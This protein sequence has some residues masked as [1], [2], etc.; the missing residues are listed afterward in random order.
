MYQ[1]LLSIGSLINWIYS[2]V[3]LCHVSRIHLLVSRLLLVSLISYVVCR[4]WRTH[5]WN[6]TLSTKDRKSA[7]NLSGVCLNRGNVGILPLLLCSPS[8]TR[9]K[10]N[11]SACLFVCQL[12]CLS[13]HLS[14]HPSVCR[15]ACVVCNKI[16]IDR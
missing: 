16:R 9:Y 14:V 7:Y 13:V 2:L 11:V 3:I 10:D 15:S 1:I 4:E 12:I 5:L 6:W 8:I